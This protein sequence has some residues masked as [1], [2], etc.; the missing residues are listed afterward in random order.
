MSKLTESTIEN[1]AIELLQAQ[2]YTYLAGSD[3]AP[4]APDAERTRY[5]EV[6]LVAR[7][8][9]AVRR[10]NPLIPPAVQDEAIAQVLRIASPDVLANNE[11]FHRLLT[12]GVPVTVQ[13][14]GESRGDFVRL[15]DFDA[16]DVNDFVVVNQFTITQNHQSKR[17]D[18]I[19]FVNGL[20]L[21]V[22]ELK[23]ATDENASVNSAHRQ[24]E[25]YMQAI[26]SLLRSMRFR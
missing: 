19:L 26:P 9:A 14:G 20:P 7:L 5:D 10:I 18:V 3:I 12:E 25:T 24:L 17:P 22:L 21:V 1:W 6:V 16:V 15:L 2:G 4:D 23:N 8:R 11:A 13:V